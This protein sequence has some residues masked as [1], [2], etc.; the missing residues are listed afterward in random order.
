MCPN[1]DIK[2]Y[3]INLGFFSQKL[4]NLCKFLVPKELLNKVIFLNSDFKEALLQDIS[5]ENIP[6]ILNGTGKFVI[7]QYPNIFDS[8]LAKSYELRTFN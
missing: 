7:N 5:E 6:Q 1:L 4:L 8:D 3:A 2:I